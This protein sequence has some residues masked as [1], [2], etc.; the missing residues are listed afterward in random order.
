MTRDEFYVGNT[1]AVLM[2]EVRWY[3][4]E[5][6]KGIKSVGDGYDHTVTILL[7]CMVSTR[8]LPRMITL[9]THDDLLQGTSFDVGRKLYPFVVETVDRFKTV[10]PMFGH[11][12]TEVE[13]R[14]FKYRDPV[15]WVD[16]WQ[17]GSVRKGIDHVR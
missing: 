10:L 13:V 15:V 17:R 8:V 2:P 11:S 9:F 14:P 7:E 1:I 4:N 3:V 16:G 6:T 12:A 5:F